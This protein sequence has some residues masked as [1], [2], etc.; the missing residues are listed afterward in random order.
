M[1]KK[2]LKNSSPSMLIGLELVHIRVLS[3]VILLLSEAEGVASSSKLVEV[4]VIGLILVKHEGLLV[5]AAMVHTAI[6]PADHLAHY[7]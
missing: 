2:G 1:A 5:H 6:L 7:A 4:V 3:S